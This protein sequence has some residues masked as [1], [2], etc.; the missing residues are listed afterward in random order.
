MCHS[1]LFY[2][3]IPPYM[4]FPPL[5]NCARSSVCTQSSEISQWHA[6]VWLYSHPSC[7]ILRPMFFSS[8]TVSWIFKLI[9][10]YFLCP[11]LQK[12]W[13]LDF[14]N[15]YSHCPIFFPCIFHPFLFSFLLLCFLKDFLNLI[16]WSFLMYLFLIFIFLIYHLIS[17]LSF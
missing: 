7:W 10:S 2:F 6:W 9:S 5:W 11:F 12:T 13:Y 3:L 4:T 8:R 15:K 16:I 14:Q 17:L 1:K